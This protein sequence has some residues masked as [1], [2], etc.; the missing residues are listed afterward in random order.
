MKPLPIINPPA[1]ICRPRLAFASAFLA[2]TA[3]CSAQAPQVFV[4]DGGHN[5]HAYAIATDAGGAFFVGG[6][7]DTSDTPTTFALLK[8]NGAGTLQWLARVQGLGDYFGSSVSDV[9]TDSAGNV[10]AVGSAF[11][12]LPFLARDYGWLVTS[13]DTNGVQRW[14]QLVNGPERSAEHARSVALD[15]Q[16]GLYVTGVRTD[17]NSSARED[18]LT[19]KYSL[20]GVEQW[21]R[22]EAGGA[23]GADQPIGAKVDASGNVIVHGWVQLAGVSGPKDLRIVKYDPQGNVLWRFTYSDTTLSDEFPGGLAIDAAG[24]IYTTGISVPSTNPED[25]SVPFILK[26]T[27]NGQQVFRLKGDG[28]G[29][30]SIAID[31]QGNVVVS[32]IAIHADGT[33]VAFP[34][35]TKFSPLGAELWT[36]PVSG[37]HVA[38]DDLDGSVYLAGEG[39]VFTAKKISASGQLQWQQTIPQ[40]GGVTDAVIDDVS[41]AL[42]MTGDSPEGHGNILTARFAAGSVPP[43]PQ[44]PAAPSA[45][46]ASARKGAITLTWTDNANNENGFLIERSTAGGPFTQIA[47][48]GANVRTFENTG[49]TKNRTYTYRVRAFNADGNSAYSNTA[50]GTAR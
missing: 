23:D 47:Q 10:Y 37:R 31:P 15:P 9:A 38:I 14:A 27:P 35:T 26:L 5:D 33:F 44:P 36:L 42:L 22:I 16:H 8:Y 20:A 25:A 40:G 49:L 1:G 7:V 11:K 39:F 50:S 32:G 4:Y 45:L 3:L 30:D 28:R 48:V 41:G 13:F 18:W 17:P 46:S 29:G 2:L 24:N 34:A 12:Q 6:F 43:Q 19:I 21:R